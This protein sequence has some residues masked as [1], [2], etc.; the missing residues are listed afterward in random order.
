MG[1]SS[2]RISSSSTPAAAAASG[3]TVSSPTSKYWTNGL[4]CLRRILPAST[5]AIS[6]VTVPSVQISIV[7]LS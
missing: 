7:S 5:S 4:M 1:M 6:G 2:L 3:E